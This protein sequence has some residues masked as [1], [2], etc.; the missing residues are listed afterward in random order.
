MAI[1]GMMK[2]LEENFLLSLSPTIT[3]STNDA[4][5]VNMYDLDNDTIWASIGSDDLTEETIEIDYGASFNVTR[6]HL[7]GINWKKYKIEA[8]D[9]SAWQA[10]DIDDSDLSSVYGQAVYGNSEYGNTTIDFEHNNLT[11][12]YFEI[13]VTTQ[14]LLITI[15]T[16]I[17]ADEEKQITE[18]YIGAEIG[19]FV[20]DLTSS[21][22][23]YTPTP[24]NSNAIMLMKSNA[25]TR[26][27]NRGSKYRGSFRIRQLWD[28]ADRTLVQNMYLT[29]SF[30]I[31]PSGGSRFYED[32][33]FRIDDFY[34]VVWDGDFSNP[35]AVGRVKEIGVDI[36][37]DLVEQ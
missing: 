23:S 30:V 26:R 14:K 16:T 6:I 24:I 20:A 11:S 1:T 17:T 29:G 4:D 31:F 21:P 2:V 7:M 13:D 5:K 27:F 33:G 8:W 19:T 28:D 3:V 34:H 10:I 32:F 35:F 37:F 36:A 22:N 25:G 15:S 9:G 12:R 18:L